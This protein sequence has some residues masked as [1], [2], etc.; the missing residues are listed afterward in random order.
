MLAL[1][2][3]RR[4]ERRALVLDEVHAREGAE[5]VAARLL[6]LMARIHAVLQ[7]ANKRFDS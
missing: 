5:E 7:L 1:D 2:A 3:L 4:G 6:A